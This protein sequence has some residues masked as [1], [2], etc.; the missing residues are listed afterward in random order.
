VVFISRI[1][2]Y[3]QAISLNELQKELEKKENEKESLNGDMRRILKK[4]GL[5][6]LDK[7]KDHNRHIKE[8]N[9][10]SKSL[11]KQQET[12]LRGKPVEDL[13]NRR[14][15]LEK[16]IGIEQSKISK[17]Q[18]TSPPNTRRQ[19]ELEQSRDKLKRELDMI[20]KKILSLKAKS[21]DRSISKEDLIEQE[22]KLFMV[23]KIT[24]QLNKRA[25]IYE[26]IATSLE[27]AQSR[28]L[29]RTREALEKMMSEYISDVT[30]GKYNDLKLTEEYDLLVYSKEKGDYVS[31]KVL[32]TGVVDQLYIVAR[33]GFI[34]LMYNTGAG[35]E[36]KRKES[37][38]RTKYRPIVLL[39]DPFVNFDDERRGNMLDV[40]EKLSH[41]FQIILFTATGVYDNWGKVVIMK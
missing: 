7:A 39:D 9:D 11:L 29:K 31:S 18:K 40:L 2:K 3:S 37:G 27:D 20:N 1:C 17:E 36:K 16:S 15:G 34:Q 33:F 24:K 22:E 10:K 6:T 21:E 5:E 28:A 32:S 8:L 26:V 19:R 4:F 35:E 13:M 23:K 41:D 38:K 14:R 12:L 30:S 25:S